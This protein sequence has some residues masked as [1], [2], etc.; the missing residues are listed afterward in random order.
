[1]NGRHLLRPERRA[2]L[3]SDTFN[4]KRLVRFVAYALIGNEE[5]NR[6]VEQQ[7]CI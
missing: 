2:R 7:G 1:M 3:S 4:V 5:E 6:Y